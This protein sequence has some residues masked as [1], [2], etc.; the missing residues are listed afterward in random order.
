M[1][2]Q[3]IKSTNVNG[4]EV[5][6]EAQQGFGAP[7]PGNSFAVDLIRP[8]DED[9]PHNTIIGRVAGLSQA[10]ALNIGS[11][12]ETALMAGVEVKL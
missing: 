6:V 11:V 8:R 9:N 7:K 3:T 10:Q 5:R 12:I 4:H 2:V 1:R